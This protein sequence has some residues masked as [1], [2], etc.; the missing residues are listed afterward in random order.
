MRILF[1]TANRL[2]DAVLST[3][4]LDHLI[5][6]HPEAR[7]TIACGPIAEGVFQR[8][9]N[10]E[11]VIVFSKLPFGGHWLL[12]WKIALIQRWNLVVDIRGSALSWLIFTRRRAIMRPALGHKT[13]QL[14]Q[15]LHLGRSPR[16]VA[17][18]NDLDI[19]HSSCL[20]PPG[21]MVIIL[22]PTANWSP[23]VWPAERFVRLFQRL[24]ATFLRDAIPAVIAGSGAEE[25]AMAAPV[26]KALPDVIDLVGR[27][28]LP[29]V[30]ALLAQSKLFIGN[31]SGL[32][33]L[34]AAS[35][36]PTLGLF[37]PTNADEYAPS[38]RRA[39][40]LVSSDATMEGISVD[41]ALFAAE[42]LLAP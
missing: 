20:L 23:K 40:A 11:R 35:G 36:A 27:L 7:I 4:L 13:Q 31:D 26:L 18:Y 38:G 30:A 15:I 41:A 1:V 10:L 37:G 34:S 42:A 5:R 24:A 17:W 21:R 2:G 33:H 19:A 25:A 22:A 29:Q 9:P 12:L 39:I 14:A 16:P 28:S 32:M 6:A 8:M 3:G